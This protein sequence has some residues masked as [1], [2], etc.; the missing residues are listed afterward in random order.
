MFEKIKKLIRHIL[1]YGLGN[2]GNRIVGFFLIPVYT[3]YLTPEDYG[4]LALVAMFGQILFILMNMGQSTALFRTY[5]TNEEPE[6]RDEVVTTS[7][8]L[9]LTLSF[10]VGLLALILARPLA[11][12]LT[13]SAAYTVW[14][15]IGIGGVA[16][17]TL[18]RMPFAVMRARE[19][20]RRYARFAFTRTMVGLVLA[21]IFVVGLHWGGRG[22]L[23]SQ[24]VTELLLSVYLVPATVK[25]L[26]PSSMALGAH[27]ASKK[28]MIKL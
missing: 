19:E 7:L 10:P 24:L 2:A 28:F 16:F 3:R 26:K 20:S 21:L 18:L 4:V 6:G 12:L 8:W 14:V 17:K 1:I 9:I 5:F 13:G 15:M 22:V 27:A 11:S 23:L 25:G